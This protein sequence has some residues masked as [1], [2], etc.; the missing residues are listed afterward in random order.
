[1][2]LLATGGLTYEWSPN[3]FIDYTNIPNPTVN[4]E[5]STTYSVVI[6]NALGCTTTLDVEVTVICDTLFIPNGFSPNDDGT[7]DG[8]VIDGIENYPGNKLWIYNRWGNLVF[9]TK[10]Y[11]NKWDGVANVAG[12]YI[13][14]K[15]PSGTYYY[16]L[17]LNDGSKPYAGYLILRR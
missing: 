12:M 10:N 6:T 2:Q 14:Q 3:S 16:I 1:V 8:Y 17:D 15:L 5:V 9:K 13:G 7:N 11:N 4:P